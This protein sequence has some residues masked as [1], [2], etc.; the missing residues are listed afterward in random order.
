MLKAL[1]SNWPCGSVFKLCGWN[2]AMLALSTLFF[3]QL[4]DIT[5]SHLVMTVLEVCDGRQI[6]NYHLL[7]WQVWGVGKCQSVKCGK[8]SHSL[9]MRTHC[10]W[11]QPHEDCEAGDAWGWDSIHYIVKH[12]L[13]LNEA[14]KVTWSIWAED[15]FRFV[16]NMTGKEFITDVSKGGF[17]ICVWVDRQGKGRLTSWQL[18]WRQ[19]RMCKPNR[20][21]VMTKIYISR[22][23]TPWL[24]NIFSPHDNENP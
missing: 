12:Q 15:F 24:C 16:W 8:S 18:C 20:E 14:W 23:V 6:G 22:K 2:M 10:E 3:L 5:Q 4:C 13:W 1:E 17:Q 7:L 11:M 21:S 19:N 9:N